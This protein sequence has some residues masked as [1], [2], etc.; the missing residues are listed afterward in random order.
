MPLLDKEGRLLGRLNLFDLFL[1]MLVF[2]LT[3]I[4]Y[5]RLTAPGRVAPPYALDVNRAVMRAELQL[6]AEQA[7]MCGVV[8]P[9]QMERDPRTGEPSA[10]VLGCAIQAGFP[11]VT[12][13]LHAVRDANGR[14]LFENEPLLPG[15]KLEIDTE[16]AILTGIVRQVA[17]ETP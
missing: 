3:A 9:G 15:R 12:L 11:V 17:P 7:W 10:E 4:A 13:R 5:Q 8:A 14:V 1:A 16:A 2:A 6:P